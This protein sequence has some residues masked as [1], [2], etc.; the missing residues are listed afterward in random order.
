MLHSGWTRSLHERGK[1]I[2]FFGQSIS[3]SGVCHGG[4]PKGPRR[5]GHPKGG[6]TKGGGAQNFVLFLPSPATVFALFLSLWV[7]GPKTN[8]TTT[9]TQQQQ[10]T[11]THHQSGLAKNGLAKIGLAKVGQTLNTPCKRSTRHCLLRS[12][13]S[14]WTALRVGAMNCTTSFASRQQARFITRA[15]VQ[16][17]CLRLRAFRG[18][19][20]P[21]SAAEGWDPPP[22]PIHEQ[23]TKKEG[24]LHNPSLR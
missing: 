18:L 11:T 8:N 24:T 22:L 17:C 12:G 21:T 10:H 15:G 6:T 13:G 7:S 20:A 2:H 23:T 9:T 19:H 16:V 14:L 1:P 4:A 5:V 3:E